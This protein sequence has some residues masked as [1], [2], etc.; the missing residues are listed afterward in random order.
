MKDYF[1]DGLSV[2]C[3]FSDSGEVLREYVPGV[4]FFVGE[5]V[6]FYHYDRLGSVRFLSDEAGQVVQEYVYDAWGNLLSSSGSLVQP[7][8]YVGREG[9]YREGGLDLYLL[10]QRWYD[11]EVGRFISRDPILS[12]MPL[13]QKVDW[14]LLYSFLEI[15]SLHPYS[16]CKSNPITSKDPNGLITQLSKHNICLIVCNIIVTL[17]TIP[18]CSYICAPLGT[19]A[20]VCGVICGVLIGYPLGK[21][22]ECACNKLFPP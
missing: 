3:E 22:C 11:E 16:Y 18:P 21:G 7:Y 17:V 5:S 14:F 10:G 19:F 9:Y 20:P 2:L 8:Q 4:C 1:L 13:K 12:S 6:Y 15:Q